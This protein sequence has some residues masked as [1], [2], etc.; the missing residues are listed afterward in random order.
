MDFTKRTLKRIDQRT[1]WFL[2]ATGVAAIL[3]R[4]LPVPREYNFSALGAFALLAGSLTR[5]PLLAMAVAL[6]VRA[7]TDCW[8][9]YKTGYGFYD[10][11]V[12]DYSAYAMIAVL[13]MVVSQR[14]VISIIG[15]GLAAAVTFFVVSNF[16]VWIS[17][18]EHQ[19]SRDFAG[20][21]KCYE[22]AIPFA[23]GTFVG[24][25]I[26]SLVFFGCWS[27]L[28]Q[29]VTVEPLKTHEPLK[30]RTENN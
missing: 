18:P 20:L 24:D 13:G 3:L 26:Y 7:V 30:T 17:A 8:L 21:L 22:M 10:G 23:R 9:E 19:Y 29:P 2:L 15:G 4:V 11:M 1:G 16:G 28:M 5:R 14:S 12:F 25:V 27:V 6:A